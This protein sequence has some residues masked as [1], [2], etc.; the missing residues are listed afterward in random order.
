MNFRRS[1]LFVH[2]SDINKQINEHER[3]VLVCRDKTASFAFK[4][5][6]IG[7]LFFRK[8]EWYETVSEDEISASFDEKRRYFLQCLTD[9]LLQMNGSDLSKGLFYYTS[10][11]FLDYVDQQKKVFDLSNQNS[12]IDAYRR[13]SKYLVDRTLLADTDEESL[14]T[15]TAKQ[16]QR[17]A[18][19]LIAYVFDCH[20]IDIVSQAMQVQS[21]RYDVPVLPI[22]KEDHQKTYATLLNVFLEIHRIVVQENDFPVHFQSVDDENFYFYSNFHH[23][24]EKQ[25]IQFDMQRYLAKYSSVPTL[26][27]MLADFEL[28]EDSEHRKRVRENRNQAIRKLE[29]RNK[30]KRHLER[31]RLVSYGLTIGML[32]FIAQTGANLDT[33]QQ[34][35]LDTM[36]IL[37]STQGRRFSGTK[38]RAGDK[39]VRPEFGVKFE[40]IFRKIL[41]LRVW[42]IQDEQCD[43]VF[44]LRN[45][46]RKLSAIGNNKL[47]LLKRFLQRI[48][49]KMAWITPQQWRKHVS[50]QYVELSD[51]DLL[52]EVEKMGHSLDTAKK[53]YSRTSFKDASQQI[54]QFFNELREV[55]V[56]KTRTLER[57]SVQMLDETIDAQSSP[58]GAC[59]SIH[60]QPEKAIGFTERAPT[61][62]CQQFEHCLFCQHYAV[63]ADDEDVRK[64][65]SLK[66]LLGYV[67]QKATDLIKWEQQF[68]V[69]LHRIDEVLNELSDTYEN[70]RDRIF[71]IQEEVE[72][73][74]LD[75]YWLNHFELLID[76]GWIS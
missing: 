30:N 44:P 5:L 74:D 25:H 23:Q 7:T 56:S 68:G 40:P 1:P 4:T 71:S 63:H 54:S 11:M 58:V 3:L 18:A 9:Y 14:A 17:N 51:G 72:S 70:L 29:E 48:F 36:E 35:Q 10:K 60:A 67:K 59:A 15:H 73:G 42:Y 26:S 12:V 49:P 33:A 39:I 28:E 69:M 19:K 2:I 6:D 8:R 55:A 75:A 64:L 37:P 21:Q 22:A 31:E 32:L 52:L 46:V 45:D 16:Y 61:P 24:T 20:E 34:L 41:E 27:K 53:N 62:N 65:L 66:S 50:S 47:Q 38:S 13:Y 76:L 57:I 43:F